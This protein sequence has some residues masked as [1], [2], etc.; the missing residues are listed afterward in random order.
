[1]SEGTI[2][3]VVTQLCLAVKALA[4]LCLVFIWMVEFFHSGVTVDA[5]IAGRTNLLLR[6]V[7]AKL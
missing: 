4:V 6:N 5:S 2:L 3:P 1:M 7:A